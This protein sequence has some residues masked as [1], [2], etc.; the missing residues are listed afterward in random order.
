M[1]RKRQADTKIVKN[2]KSGTPMV[3]TQTMILMGCV[4]F[5]LG[6]IAG[7]AFSVYKSGSSR[8]MAGQEGGSGD[9]SLKQM[10]LALEKELQKNPKNAS[11][12]TQLG[13]VYFDMNQYQKAIDAYGRSLEINPFNADVLTD[14]GV[15]YRRNGQP[16]KAIESFN[17]ALKVDPR[18]EISRFNK[19]IVFLH[20]LKDRKGAIA[21]WED[22][23]KMN[24]LARA[25]NGQ[26][27]KD[28]IEFYK[29][30]PS[31]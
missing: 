8:P 20:D 2:E 3:K 29:N 1:A 4:L 7:V 30:N 21:A 9:G 10:A 24:P 22:L 18:H 26:S 16:E 25:P 27:V 31:N 28:L 23:L 14:R 13:N 19:G 6:F 5:A 12:W 15:M 17:Q 11:A